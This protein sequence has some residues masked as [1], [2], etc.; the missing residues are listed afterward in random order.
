MK[1]HRALGASIPRE[2]VGEAER[3]LVTG[4]NVLVDLYLVRGDAQGALGVLS[5]SGAGDL[6]RKDLVTAL[7]QGQRGAQRGCTGST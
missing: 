1:E 7:K 3:A 5:N 4:A 2:E 6:A